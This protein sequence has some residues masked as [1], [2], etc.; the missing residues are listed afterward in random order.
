MFLF[1]LLAFVLFAGA[2]LAAGYYMFSL[3]EKAAAGT[4]QHRLR[5]LRAQAAGG[6]ARSSRADLFRREERGSF[7]WLGELISW[8]GALAR[9]QK[10]INQADMK[11]RA[12]DVAG[13]T[14]LLFL[15][16]F[17][18]FGLFIPLWLLRTLFAALFA[19]IPLFII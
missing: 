17:L 1:F 8:G 4:L 18:V 2:F 11:Y 6:E 12:A 13:V 5:D 9:L 19:L 3:P 16:A 15:G 7:A 10:S 14:V